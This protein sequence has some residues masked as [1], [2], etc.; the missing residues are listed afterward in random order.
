MTCHV[1]RHDMFKILAQKREQVQLTPFEYI[2]YT[3]LTQ[4]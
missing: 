3:S 4:L 2:V 1:L